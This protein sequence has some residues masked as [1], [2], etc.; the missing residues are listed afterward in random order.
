MF[1]E[2]AFVVPVFAMLGY[3]VHWM[4]REV[5]RVEDSMKLMQA[6]LDRIYE[7]RVPELVADSKTG[8]YFPSKSDALLIDN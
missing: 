3:A 8:V 1:L 2:F 5:R 7:N 6:R 4:N